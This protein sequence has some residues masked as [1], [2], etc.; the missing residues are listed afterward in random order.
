MIQPGD[1]PDIVRPARPGNWQVT[2]RSKKVAEAWREL[3]N[4]FAGECQRVYDQLQ[5]DPTFD[6]GDRQH[7]LEGEAGRGSFDG[8][9]MRRW[10]I[11][12]TSGARIWYLVDATESGSGQKRRSGTVII[13]QVHPGHPKGTERKPSGKR[14]P[15]RS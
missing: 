14:R 6:D 9:A 12:V 1:L 10:Q 13:D 4:Q 15:G 5:S 8:R 11:D 3:A 2:A 7:P